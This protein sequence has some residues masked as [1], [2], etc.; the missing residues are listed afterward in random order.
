MRRVWITRTQ[1]QADAT[2]ARLLALGFEPVVAPVLVTRPV[3]DAGVD[4]SG[5]EALA[6]TSATGVRAFAG[7][8]PARDLPVFAVGSATAEAARTAGFDDVQIGGGDVHAL[9]AAILAA[10]P[11]RVLNPTARAPAADLT[12]LL[13]AHGVSA[14]S[15]VVYETVPTEEAAPV[16]IDALL[17][18]S[19][20][21]ARI[22]ADLI[23][24]ARAAALRA[25]VISEAAA[26]PLRT[27]AFATIATA[28]FPD[29]A[30]LLD[31][32]QG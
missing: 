3:A 26:A 4:L 14:S 11:G 10:T 12:A 6:F 16:D 23:S 19:P 8:S 13:A 30:S 2:A 5:V 27:L 32:L 24:S 20:R 29:E 21:A 22:V 7:L 9:V 18:H 25:F 15:I 28:L 31:L 1:P 17:V